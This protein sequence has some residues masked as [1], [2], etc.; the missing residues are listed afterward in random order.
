MPILRGT[1]VSANQS[2]ESTDCITG[3]LESALVIVEEGIQMLQDSQY[4]GDVQVLSSMR[5]NVIRY[6]RQ[7]IYGYNDCTIPAIGIQ[8]FRIYLHSGNVGRPRLLVNMDQVELL[9]GCGY[10]WD[11]V[12][13]CLNVS[14]STLWRRLREM[15]ISRATSYIFCERCKQS[16]AH[17]RTSQSDTLAFRCSWGDRR[18]RTFNCLFKLQ[19]K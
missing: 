8:P 17:R 5:Q 12:S 4:S 15:N 6:M 1:H 14:R 16:M 10:T 9:R 2:E 11:E 18:L 3:Q 13:G 7:L 19:H